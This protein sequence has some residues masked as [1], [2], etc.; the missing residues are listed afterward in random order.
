MRHAVFAAAIVVA[1]ACGVVAP[2]VAEAPLSVDTPAYKEPW[3][4]YRG[5]P[6]DDWSKFDTL[7][8]L[9]SPPAV[10]A[11]RKIDGDIT[12][13]PEKGKALA[14]D[15]RRGGS[16]LACHVMG[17]GE[18]PGS[19]GPDLSEVGTWGRSDEELF[20]TVYDRRVYH[21]ETVMPPWGTN[22]VFNDEEIRDIVAFLKTL[23]T[24][25]VFKTDLD[26]PSKRP[27]P[28][29]DRNNK[30]PFTNPAAEILDDTG[31]ATFAKA[32][33]N[34]KSCGTCH[35][36]GAP[37]KGWAA[38]MPKWEP[39]LD[40]IMGVEEFLA[41]HAK[42]TM[43]ADW[44]MQSPENTVLAVFV[45]SLSDGMP[46]SPDISSP[47]AR[48]ALERAEAMTRRKIGQLNLA[49]VDCHQ[50]AAKTWIRGQ[51]LGEFKGQM[52]HFPT[53][54]TSRQE[55]WDIRKRFQWCGVAI[56]ANEL[57]PDAPE[58]GDLELFLT[59]ANQGLE[60]NA[61]GIRH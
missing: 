56:R 61:P 9:A 54:R 52:P 22:G 31:P 44:L 28:V 8:E 6:Q 21:P 11:P 41:R 23:K 48:A 17:S 49:C 43:G 15:R 35:G 58:Y 2:A 4:R 12:G 13:D 30:D 20:N 45:R 39:R 40:K 27:E 26:D 50:T 47:E 59:K 18:L 19:V 24:P 53:W 10:T 42:A 51:W 5:W 7:R 55:I 3:T 34:G 36:E 16:C 46:I 60:I 32:G 29:E 38:T 33:P 1:A 37:L 14:F 25:A 57:P